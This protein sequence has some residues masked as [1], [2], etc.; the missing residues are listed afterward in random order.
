MTKM[1]RRAEIEFTTFFL[2]RLTVAQR[3]KLNNTSISPSKRVKQS[4][5][6]KFSP[7]STLTLKTV[8]SQLLSTQIN[9]KTLF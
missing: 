6:P 4:N 1:L 2:P 5:D 8:P 9:P 3:F 7:S